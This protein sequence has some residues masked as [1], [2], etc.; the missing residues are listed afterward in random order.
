MEDQALEKKDF[1]ANPPPKDDQESCNFLNCNFSESD[2]KGITF[3]E[4][5]LKGC[6]LSLVKTLGMAFKDVQV[7]DCKLP[8]LHFVD[9]ANAD[10]SS[11]LF[12]YCDHSDTRFE[13]TNLEK[14]GFRTA[15]NYALDPDKNRTKG[16]KYFKEGVAELLYRYEIEIS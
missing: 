5:S 6:N 15:F 13:N 1:Y 7:K 14:A 16:A 12:A 9:I 4:F 3:S 10:L 8:G 11:A 2:L